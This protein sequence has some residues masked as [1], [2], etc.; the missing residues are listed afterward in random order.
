MCFPYYF[1]YEISSV[2]NV[3]PWALSAVLIVPMLHDVYLHYDCHHRLPYIQ[4]VN[5]ITYMPWITHHL[6]GI[7][8]PLRLRPL[9]Q[10]LLCRPA[11]C[12]FRP[13]ASRIFQSL[14]LY[15]WLALSPPALGFPYR[16]SGIKYFRNLVGFHTCKIQKGEP[17]QAI[18]GKTHQ[19]KTKIH[20]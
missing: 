17:L 2:W 9:V 1:S 3:L 5:T 4:I 8:D 12:G 15:P 7:S 13:S 16:C 11:L 10:S 6:W 18:W 19:W 14:I 20:K